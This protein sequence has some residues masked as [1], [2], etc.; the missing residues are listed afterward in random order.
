MSGKVRK[1][2]KGRRKKESSRRRENF[3]D[4]R[5]LRETYARTEDRLLH[6]HR[7]PVLQSPHAVKDADDGHDQMDPQRGNEH[8]ELLEDGDFVDD[9][10]E[11]EEEDQEGDAEDEE[12][13]AERSPNDEE[14]EVEPTNGV[15]EP[16]DG[17]GLLKLTRGKKEG[18]RDETLLVMKIS[19]NKVQHRRS[20]GATEA[21]PK[22]KERVRLNPLRKKEREGK[23][24]KTSH[25]PTK[26]LSHSNPSPL[27]NGRESHRKVH[28]GTATGELL[29]DVGLAHELIDLRLLYLHLFLELCSP[30]HDETNR[31][32]GEGK[33]GGGRCGPGRGWFSD[34][35]RAGCD[36]SVDWSVR[37][38][39][40][41]C[42][43]VEGMC[44]A[45]G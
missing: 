8:S 36:W 41:K 21:A 44:G 42:S 12:G 43:L 18:R 2:R 11:G 24:S 4:T 22:H 9:G 38:E 13:N 31:K 7:V 23:S 3:P 16:G 40:L 5:E 27:P 30:D 1:V 26:E 39:A 10:E 17:K 14:Q 25:R 32:K 6:V 35:K 15:L 20:E 34:R 29:D 37:V 28:R 45:V 33:K 19:R